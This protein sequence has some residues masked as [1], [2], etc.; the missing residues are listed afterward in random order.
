M[1]KLNKTERFLRWLDRHI[2]KVVM[3]VMIVFLFI[4]NKEAYNRAHEYQMKM[5]EA[6]EKYKEQQKEW[7][8]CYV[9]QAN[10]IQM[11]TKCERDLHEMRQWLRGCHKKLGY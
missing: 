1:R 8:A 4:K 11:L 10:K 6:T 3:A 9:T 2:T 5:I 7:S